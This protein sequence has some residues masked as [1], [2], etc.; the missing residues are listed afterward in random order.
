[1][2]TWTHQALHDAIA[3]IYPPA[4]PDD[5]ATAQSGEAAQL[6]I[7]GSWAFDVAAAAEIIRRRPR[8]TTRLPVPAWARACGLD[9]NQD[10]GSASGPGPGPGLDRAYAMTADLAEP[11]IIAAVPLPLRNAAYNVLLDGRHRL[12]RAHV[13]G[14]ASLRGWALTDDETLAV[15]TCR[16]SAAARLTA[17]TPQS[18]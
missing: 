14:V 2:T 3:A 1:M 9:Q 7:V 15:L 11:L 16:T 5:P 6:R 12:Y 13:E 10:P 17:A 8:R 4:P 18:A